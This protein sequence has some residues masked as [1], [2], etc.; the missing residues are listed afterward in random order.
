MATAAAQTKGPAAPKK[1]RPTAAQ[2]PRALVIA[3]AT[4]IDGT[5]APPV[6]DAIVVIRGERIV[7]A[8]PHARVQ[9]PRGAWRTNARGK[10]VIPGL[11]DAHVHFFQSGGLYTRPDV[12]DLRSRVPYAEELATIRKRLPYT[13]TRYLCS[14]ITSAVDVGGPMWNFQVREL[15]A[16]TIDAPRVAVAGPLISSYAPPAL[17]T[18]DPAII[19]VSTPE[20]ARGLADKELAEKPDLVK[21]WFIRRPD[22]KL[23]DFVPIVEATVKE[24]HARGVRVAVH[25]TELSTAK[26]AVHAGADVLVHSVMDKPVDDE[27][28]G[29]VKSRGVIYTTTLVVLEGYYNVLRQRAQVSDFDRQCGDPNVIATWGDLGKIP[30]NE[31]PPI[32]AQMSQVPERMKNSLAN[33][34]RMQDAGAIIAAGTDAGNIGTLHGPSLHRE[35]ELMAE[36]GLTPMQILVAA[37]RNA[38]RVSAREPEMGTVAPGKL[39]D[40]V[41]LDADPLADIRNTRRIHAVIKGGRSLPPSRLSFRVRHRGREVSMLDSARQRLRDSSP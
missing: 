7:A 23:E 17:E 35:F 4:L 41:I 24:S 20:E 3:G 19:R 40:L 8:G 9:I 30:E 38:A 12:I 6:Q 33:L 26:A 22:M 5:G 15:A 2:E 31:R 29:L 13:F 11:V 10:W 16:R 18:D 27:F 25:A 32:P 14:G 1:S 37:T 36:A 28:I 39:A 34:K 21:I